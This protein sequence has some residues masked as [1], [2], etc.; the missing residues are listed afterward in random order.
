MKARWYGFSAGIA[1]FGIAL[2]ALGWVFEI[3]FSARVNGHQFDR[4]R[5][6]ATECEL[7][8]KLSF[9]APADKYDSRAQNR[10]YHRFRAK[11]AFR[12]GKT[13]VTPVFFN[14]APGRRAYR[15]RIDTAGDG[16]WAKQKTEIQKIDV[17]GCRAQGCK[18]KEFD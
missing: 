18:V 14:R 10:N 5:A 9:D 15:T 7:G 4:I 2:P 16:C 11:I 3:P 1:L 17:E 12:N 8:I 13:V 6:Q